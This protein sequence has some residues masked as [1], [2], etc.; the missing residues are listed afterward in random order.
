LKLPVRCK[1]SAL[2]RTLPPSLPFKAADSKRGVSA[3]NGLSRSA[4]SPIS[5]N[6]GNLIADPTADTRDHTG[7]GAFLSRIHAD[8]A[9]KTA[10]L[11][12]DILKSPRTGVPAELLGKSAAGVPVKAQRGKGCL[13]EIGPEN[14]NALVQNDILR[15]HHI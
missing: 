11:G 1:V 13:F 6:V 7:N 5:S 9:P 12:D 10:S 8:G 2:M 15:T 3:A 4:A 14:A